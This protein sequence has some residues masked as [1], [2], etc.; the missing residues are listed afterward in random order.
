MFVSTA[1]VLMFRQLLHELDVRESRPID[2]TDH[3]YFGH[4][5]MLIQRVCYGQ[6]KSTATV[7]F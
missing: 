6:G 5:L 4:G 3:V 1:E 2:Q 7:P